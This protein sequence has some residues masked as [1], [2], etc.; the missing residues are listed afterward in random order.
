V[1]VA[2]AP[3]I[4]LAWLLRLRWLAIFGQL[5]ITGL[6]VL[7]LGISLPLGLVLALIGFTALSNF[8]LT[9]WLR[10]G[11]PSS[12]ALFAV[13]VLDILILTGL[14]LS[15]GGASNPFSV[16]YL[17]HVALSALLLPPRRAWLVTALT[18][19]AFALL[20]VLPSHVI[21]PHAMHMLHGASS[22]HLQGMWLAY[23]LAAGFVVHFVSRVAS[24]LQA[25]EREL[26]ELQRSAARTEKLA[27]LSTL[28]AGAAHE[29][30]TPLGTIALVAKELERGLA[31]GREPAELSEDARLIR[32][33]V[34][35][36][37]DILQRM[38]ANAG[39]S[40]GEM[41]A[42]VSISGLERSLS[43]TLG[44]AGSQLAFERS[45]EPLDLVLPKRLLL[46]VL[47][48]LV[49]NAFDAQAEAGSSD[50]V[51]VVSRV[52]TDRAAFEILDHG[53]GIPD[54]ART[55]VGEPFFTT[56][57]PGRGLGLGVFLA[58]AFAEKMGG[59]LTLLARP[60]GGTLAR[61]TLPRD[62][63]EPRSGA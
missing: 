63:L 21:D 34:E 49:R 54:H 29:L 8:A 27:S 20:F 4:G 2:T 30:G 48:N 7:V 41:P 35:R 32:Q 40:A 46:Q 10:S 47:V 25:R 37:R 13:L 14:L 11:E 38:A 53:A 9:F 61:L 36:C 28:A 52:E 5:T 44:P 15:A 33:E 51:R 19:L 12:R 42:T 22:F 60:G 23:S 57:A 59:E 45:G 26:F 43:D 31:Q 50:P 56:K 62:M 17:V 58:R 6:A 55:R 3:K 39:E 16:F 24:S 18:S 1:T